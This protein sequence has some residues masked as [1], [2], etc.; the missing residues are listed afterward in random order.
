M[1]ICICQH[2]R[3]FF[4]WAASTEPGRSYLRPYR[5]RYI[6]TARQYGPPCCRRKPLLDPAF[7]CA[8][9]FRIRCEHSERALHIGPIPLV[10]SCYDASKRCM[11]SC[12]HL[13]SDTLRKRRTIE[14]SSNR[15]MP[16]AHARIVR[17]S[18]ASH[19]RSWRAVV[20]HLRSV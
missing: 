18:I 6:P 1:F 5:E 9:D 7:Y 10:V 2:P 12:R 13:S 16:R 14:D 15:R 4:S 17:H 19:N 3:L 11:G 20:A 8:L